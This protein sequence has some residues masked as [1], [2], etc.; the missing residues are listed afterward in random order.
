M[1][2]RALKKPQ[3]ELLSMLK[4]SACFQIKKWDKTYASQVRE[5]LDLGYKCYKKNGWV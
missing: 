3:R 5:A 1:S 4:G 2:I